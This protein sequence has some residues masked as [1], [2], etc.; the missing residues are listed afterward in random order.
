MEIRTS[1][2]SRKALYHSYIKLKSPSSTELYSEAKSAVKQYTK[3]KHKLYDTFSEL[4][5]GVWM[6]KPT[7][8]NQFTSR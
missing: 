6:R 7:E 8:Q 5:L 2:V 4:Q 3:L 1:R